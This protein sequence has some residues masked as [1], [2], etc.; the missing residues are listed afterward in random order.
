M[1]IRLSAIAWERWGLADHPQRVD[2]VK[3]AFYLGYGLFRIEQL[4]LLD[5]RDPKVE[6]I[7]GTATA[8]GM[9]DTDVIKL[10][11]A[12]FLYEIE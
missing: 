1:V 10:D 6:S 11:E 3:A 4:V 5:S 12:V 9:K 2:L 7:I 8:L